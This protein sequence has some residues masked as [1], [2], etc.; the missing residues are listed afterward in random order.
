MLIC[1][2][3]K[4]PVPSA[5][6]QESEKVPDRMGRVR[7]YFSGPTEAPSAGR[8]QSTMVVFLTP[9]SGT[10]LN[11]INFRQLEYLHEKTGVKRT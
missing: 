8:G 4:T 5:T 3:F 6:G 10:L 9:S 1:S 7:H 2:T 11:C